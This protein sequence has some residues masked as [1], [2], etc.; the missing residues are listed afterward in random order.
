ME[1]RVAERLRK[2]PPYLFEEIDRAKNKAVSEGR[3][4]ID[5]GVGDP[6]TPTPDF[7]IKKLHEASMDPA[8]HKYALNRGLKTLRGAMA[9]WF[10]G[11]FGVKVDPATEVLPLLGSKEGI[12]HVPLA[13]VEPGDVVLVPDPGYPPYNSGAIFAGGEVHFMPLLEKNGFL[14]DLDAIDKDIAKRARLIHINYPNNPTGAVCGKDFYE[15]VVRFAR[16][17]NIIVCADAAYTEMSYDGYKPMS[18]LEVE[19]AKEVGIEFHSLSKTFNM[20]GWRVGMAIGDPEIINGLAKVKSN[21]DSGIFTAIQIASIEAL[22]K[23]DNVKAVL[24]RLYQG[25]RD[26]LVDGLRKAGW[27]VP[28][29]KATF[30]V[31]APVF[32]AYD[33]MS[34]AKDMLEK[35]DIIVTPGNGFGPNGEGYVRMALTVGEETIKEAVSR[36]KNAFFS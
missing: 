27:N 10:E 9:D 23:A 24:S 14:P 36:I 3:P 7:I 16:E 32:G 11:R 8:T 28:S 25:R 21:I 12:A 20:T 33:S 29:P 22:K 35:A 5:L 13:F 26:V 17:N 4:V 34:L 31:W 2:L 19:G 30:Y 6:D 1:V 18:F 15:K